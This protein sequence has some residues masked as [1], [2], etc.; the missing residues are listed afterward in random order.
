LDQV[1]KETR[2]ISYELTPSVLRDFGFVAG[3]KEMAQRLRTK[4]FIIDTKI[5]SEAD[6]LHPQIQLY[7]FR[8]IQ[9]LIN[10]CIKHANASQ[11]QVEVS[12]END[13]VT[14]LVVD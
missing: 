6:L 14:L 12:I 8:I 7:L 9:E 2:N 3:I 11:V 5:A 4:T 10:N 1:I 13:W